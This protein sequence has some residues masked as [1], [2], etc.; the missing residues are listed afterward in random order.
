[1]AYDNLNISN[2]VQTYF[3]SKE[4]FI[5]FSNK[6]IN[7]FDD[8]E[9]LGYK[10]INLNIDASTYSEYGE[11]YPQLSINFEY[12]REQTQEEIDEENKKL[13]EEKINKKIQQELLGK[14]SNNSIGSIIFNDDL[15]Q[16]Y[17]DGK[18]IING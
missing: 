13:E 6:I 7:H 12:E 10:N 4:E 16:L 5:E 2:D 11:V 17:L 9:K 15:K 14:L 18:I 3:E 8:L 1:M